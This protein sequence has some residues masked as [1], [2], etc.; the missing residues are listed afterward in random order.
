LDFM[1]W[2]GAISRWWWWKCRSSQQRATTTKVYRKQNKWR[3]LE[4]SFWGSR[5]TKGTSI[6]P[7]IKIRG[8]SLRF[9]F[10]KDVEMIGMC[11]FQILIITREAI[12]YICFI[13]IILVFSFNKY[14]KYLKLKEKARVH[15]LTF[16]CRFWI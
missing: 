9:L 15:S 3:K 14:D 1:S 7:D 6:G 13:F 11:L 8:L 12:F 10:K 5:L 16:S 4:I 2:W